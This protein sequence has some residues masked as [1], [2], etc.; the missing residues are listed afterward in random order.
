MGALGSVSDGFI[1]WGNLTSGAVQGTILH[2][3]SVDGLTLVRSVSAWLAFFGRTWGTPGSPL[4][5]VLGC[6]VYHCGV[7]VAG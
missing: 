6:A 3:L 5:W 1:Y 2:P 4:G 7:F